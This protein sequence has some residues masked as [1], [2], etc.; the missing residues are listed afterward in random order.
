MPGPIREWG[1]EAKRGRK[2]RAASISLRAGEAAGAVK[3]REVTVPGFR[4]DL[5]A[6]I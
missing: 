6:L 3:T 5:F 1:C 2:T 4:H